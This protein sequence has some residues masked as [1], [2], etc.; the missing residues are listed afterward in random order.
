MN[1]LQ[2]ISL[3]LKKL[4]DKINSISRTV[5]A[6]GTRLTTAETKI[7]DPALRMGTKREYIEVPQSAF[8]N[9]GNAFTDQDIRF[10][11][12][13]SKPLCTVH[14]VYKTAA[15]PVVQIAPYSV[16][17]LGCRLR[18]IVGNK[19]DIGPRYTVLLRVEEMEN[20]T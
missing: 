2:V 16:H 6:L 13:Y 9:N 11:K 3:Q 14:I 20:K 10:S 18:Y 7:S 8:N 17:L 12:S 15:M 19:K 1:V 5:S 4:L